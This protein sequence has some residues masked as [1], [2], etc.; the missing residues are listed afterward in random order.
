MWSK[1]GL[2]YF[3]IMLNMRFEAEQGGA[4]VAELNAADLSLSLVL[5][6]GK[7]IDKLSH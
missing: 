2:A 3:D 5:Y 7:P 4:D 6:D 1:W